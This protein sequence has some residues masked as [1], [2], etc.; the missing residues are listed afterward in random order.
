MRSIGMGKLPAIVALMLA[1]AI[2]AFNGARL[3]ALLYTQY[4]G[5]LVD[6]HVADSH[7][8]ATQA[9][10]LAP[11]QL[12]GHRAQLRLRRNTAANVLEASTESL[13]WAPS[14]P[15]LWFEF[16]Q[17]AALRGF[18]GDT[19]AYAL[20][21]V[22]HLAENSPTL[23]GAVTHMGIRHWPYGDAASRREWL[24]SA[25]FVLKTNGRQYLRAAKKSGGAARLCWTLG[26]EL[27]LSV[28][29]DA[30]FKD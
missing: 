4:S 27:N 12:G 2:V 20:R 26:P 28:W 15:Y 11:W 18:Y 7:S 30:H 8:A 13:R 29:C 3:L 9:Q 6:S 22:N 16:A 14:D 17:A 1:S 24:A 23:Q 5:E 19:L 21:Q 25:R 10:T